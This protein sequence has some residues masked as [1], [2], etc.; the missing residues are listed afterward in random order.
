MNK[1]KGIRQLICGM[2][3]VTVFFALFSSDALADSLPYQSYNY[4]Y[5]EDIVYTPA[6]YEPDYVVDG[7][8]LTYQG[9]AVGSFVTPQ[10]ITVAPDGTIYLADTGNNRIVIMDASAREVKG[11]ITSFENNGNTDTFNQPYGVAVSEK[12]QLYIAD[13]QNRRIVVLN[14]DG[15]LDRIVQNPVSE[16]LEE[17]YVF[18]PLKVTVDYADR[19]YCVAQNMFE[20]IMVFEEDGS[21]TGF[22]GTINVNISLWEKFWRKI[23]TKEERAKSQLFIPTEFTGVDVDPDGFVYASNI[24]TNGK[25]GVRRL[26]PKG[27]D[28]IRKGANENLGG[29]LWIDGNTDY[30]G[31]SQFTDVVYR[32]NGIYSCM[33]RRRGRIFTYDHEGNLL[34]IFGGIGTQ[35]G[36]FQL[37][38]AIE[39]V[40]GDLLV[41]DATKA[42]LTYFKETE[43][44]RL[45]N[46]AV[47]LRYDGDEKAA[48]ELWRQVLLLDENNELANTGI[49]KAYLTAG[50]Y[51]LA[52]KYL[53]LGM[54]REYYSI[55][56]RRYRNEFLARYIGSFLSG[57]LILIIG[58]VIYAKLK[59][60]SKAAG[61]EKETIGFDSEKKSVESP[62]KDK[63]RYLWHTITH[64]MNGYYWIRHRERG[65]VWV[66]I[67][68][69]FLFSCSFS[70]NRLLSGFVI[71]DV[72]ARSVNSLYE[73]ISVMLLLLLLCVSN[74]SVTCLM[75]GEGR[76]KD[77]VIAIGYGT[78][79]V[80]IS[81]IL[82]T[83]L[84]HTIADKEQ[85]FYY[86]C[87]AI[88]ITYG[89]I[90]ML[91]GIM[92]V[93]NYT[94]GKTLI[95]VFL[96]FVAFLIFVFL[97]LL[98]TDLLGMVVGFFRSIY[99]E[100]I[101]RG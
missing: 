29:D 84:S 2:I 25:Q 9:E 6:P 54:S 88:G 14:K 60:R 97:I 21:F 16:V 70:A 24:D 44:G 22:F 62:V 31:P 20:G 45:I 48:V 66:A 71:N 101:F 26:N 85:A 12:E 23:A 39:S 89:L 49:G 13:S 74:W 87:I 40:G 30:A 75:N 46:Q 91:I 98:L 38:A 82:A 50:E 57:L 93:H 68:M 37:P 76:L 94:L 67:L 80:S 53:E 100:I 36:T 95:T 17:D 11:I 43:Y 4:N 90:M 52:M 15:S 78:V 3:M 56:F 79:P 63:F 59:R 35:N 64:P 77:I 69:V 47:A 73:L 34:Y 65:S 19:I 92:Q 1:Y 5:W 86:L 42:N 8:S 18:V 10:D 7:L 61:S 72:D 32:E 33:D 28:V 55:A 51:E 27:E 96:T 58:G 41:L 81:L 99:M 83:I